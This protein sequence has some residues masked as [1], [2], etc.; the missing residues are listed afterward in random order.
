MV[1][2]ITKANIHITKANIHYASLRCM[3]IGRSSLDN[4]A[5]LTVSSSALASLRCI[6]LLSFCA[7][8]SAAAARASS[9]DVC[10]LGYDQVGM[11]MRIRWA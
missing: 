1:Q 8:A 3:K 10:V 2:T 11:S 7:A 5:A 6:A 4:I 9:C